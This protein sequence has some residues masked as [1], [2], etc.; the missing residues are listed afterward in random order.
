MFDN[1]S[2][3]SIM[4]SFIYVFSFTLLWILTQKIQVSCVLRHKTLF[5]NTDF[6]KNLGIKCGE[7]YLNYL[8]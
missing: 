3:P 8:H 1:I 6:N 5:K 7:N 4:Y 2:S